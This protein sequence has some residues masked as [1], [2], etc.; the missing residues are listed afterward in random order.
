MALPTTRCRVAAATPAAMVAVPTVPALPELHF[1]MANGLLVVRDA[2]FVRGLLEQH[3][4]AKL[5]AE[6][7]Q[8]AL[9]TIY[10]LSGEPDA[11]R[12]YGG[13]LTQRLDISL[14]TAYALI[15]EG[16][17]RYTCTGKKNYRVSERAVREYLGDMP[18]T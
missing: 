5:A 15:G 14:S 9:S 7:E 10:R 4:A 1:E 2:A 17:L 11:T 13:L 16:K 12:P 8:A 3:Q 6:A 18:P